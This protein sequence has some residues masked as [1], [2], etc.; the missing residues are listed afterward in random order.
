MRW[1]RSVYSIASRL[2]RGLLSGAQQLFNDKV[3]KGDYDLQLL[4]ESHEWLKTADTSHKANAWLKTY[5]KD[6]EVQY[7]GKFMEAGKLYF[8]RYI[9][10]KHYQTLDYWDRGPLV[11]CLGGYWS[12]AGDYIEI[13]L[14]LH[15]LPPLIRRQVLIKVFSMYSEKYKGEM[16]SASQRPLEINWQRI[17]MPLLQ[18]GAAFCIRQYIPKLRSQCIEFKYEDWHNAVFVPNEYL[19]KTSEE[20]LKNAWQQFVMTKAM[21]KMT[22]SGLERALGGLL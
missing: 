21:T 5:M 13:G 12:S 4:I 19:H 11:L 17:A 15:L 6:K 1:T 7:K 2:A 9:K 22:A 16:Y 14:N 3:K 8:F 18:Y 10:P 20:Q